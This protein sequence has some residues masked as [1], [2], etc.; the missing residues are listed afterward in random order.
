MSHSIKSIFLAAG[1]TAASALSASA[2]LLDFTAGTATSGNLGGGITWSLSAT[3]GIVNANTPAD[4]IPN[5]IPGAPL[6]LVTDGVGVS[7]R[8]GTL[9]DEV[10]GV[11]ET[12]TLTFS[13]IIFLQGVH[14]LDLF[15]SDKGTESAIVLNDADGTEITT[16]FASDVLNQGP[17]ENGYG[18]KALAD[19]AI[20]SITFIAGPEKDDDKAD[21]A[22]AAIN[23]RSTDGSTPDT[24][25][26]P[27]AGFLLLGALAGLGLARR[28]KT[29]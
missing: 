16:V 9:D 25:P 23:Y 18:F 28:R 20:K 10:T 27:A 11:G 12:L 22:L 17:A 2:A 15:L 13:K 3:G 19:L 29:A 5:P 1:I 8:S 4:A 21:F 26:L 24:V 14:F 7:K 6:A